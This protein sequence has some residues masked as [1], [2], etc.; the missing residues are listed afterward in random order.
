M[1]AQV[2]KTHP[3]QPYNRGTGGGNDRFFQPTVAEKLSGGVRDDFRRAG[4]LKYVVKA[5]PF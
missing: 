2:R 5:E 3:D 4:N 1:L